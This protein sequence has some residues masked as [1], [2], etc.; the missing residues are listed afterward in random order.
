MPSRSSSAAAWLA[1]IHKALKP[2]GVLGIVQHRAADDA[3]P[4]AA[5]EKGRVP[6]PALIA[7]VEAAGFKLVGKSEVN[8]NPKDEKNYEHG[9]WNLPPTLRMG[10]TDREKYTAIGE[11]DRMTLK[12]V[13]VDKPAE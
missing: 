3:D 4:K 12:F 11:S 2:K 8:A 5:A 9:V 1:E 7:Q 13:R 6:Q 10:D